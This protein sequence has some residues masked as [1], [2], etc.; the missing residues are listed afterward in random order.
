[1]KDNIC[2]FIFH[3]IFALD[4]MISAV[5]LIE[6]FISKEDLLKTFFAAFSLCFFVDKETDM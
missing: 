4:E 6:T 2:Q 3:V 5:G 1:M